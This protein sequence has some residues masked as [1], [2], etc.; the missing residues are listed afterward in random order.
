MFKDRHE[1]GKLLAEKLSEYKNTNTIIF[2]VPRGGVVV[3]YEVASKLN[4]PLDLAIPRK[5]GAPKQPELAIGAVAQDGT[6]VLDNQLVRQLGVSR[7]YIEEEARQQI[8]EIERRLKKYR[9]DLKQYPNIKNKNVILIDD[10]IA[11]G[12]TIKAAI[13]SLRKQEPASII[14]AIP[15][16]PADTID[17]LREEAD[18]VICLETP[19]TF[20]AIGQFYQDFTQ[21][22]DEEV[23]N[24]IKKRTKKSE[25]K[26]SPSASSSYIT[27]IEN[28]DKFR[29]NIE[30]K[31][32]ARKRT[33]GPYR[34][35]ALFGKQ[36]KIAS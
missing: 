23:I 34:K 2:A 32:K 20:Y 7:D 24:L 9:G 31:K 12:A 19:Q 3:A 30:K 16:G 17:S 18:K 11:T 4:V 1:A 14:I 5:I 6:T 15:V 13:L 26:F 33:R 21:T 27:R 25:T 22:T 35:A 10:G 8:E 36:K 29:V 28:E